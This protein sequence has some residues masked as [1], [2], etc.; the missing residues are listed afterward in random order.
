MD[1]KLEYNQKIG[2]VLRS[3]SVRKDSGIVVCEANRDNK[4]ESVSLNVIVNREL[5]FLLMI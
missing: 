1:E 5:I 3:P 2:F 4:T